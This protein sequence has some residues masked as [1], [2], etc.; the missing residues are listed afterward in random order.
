LVGEQDREGKIREGDIR[1]GDIRG[2]MCR[3]GVGAH[4]AAIIA[5]PRSIAGVDPAQADGTST[6][7]INVL[8]LFF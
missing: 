5:P 7:S 4:R 2:G 6:G 3:D 8:D 1:E